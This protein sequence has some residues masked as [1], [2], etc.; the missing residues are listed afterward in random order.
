MNNKINFPK[1]FIL[2]GTDNN[3]VR[4]RYSIEKNEQFPGIF[5]KFMG[6]LGFDE[7]EIDEKF[8]YEE[9]DN[10]GQ[11]L[12]KMR[13][14]VSHISDECWY[15]KNA[16]YEVDVFFGSKK[17]ILVIRTGQHNERDRRAKLLD[18][19]ESKSNWKEFP[20]VKRMKNKASAK[21]QIIGQSRSKKTIT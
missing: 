12:G 6:E 1:E 17:I 7:L 18:D 5:V 10:S 16:E 15:Y 21:A 13:V 4:H 20:V 11:P 9:N 19:L 8:Y 2:F 3:G 14:V